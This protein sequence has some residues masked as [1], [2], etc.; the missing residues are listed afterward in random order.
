[1]L[2]GGSCLEGTAVKHGQG[3]TAQCAVPRLKH[4][5]R[6]LQQTLKQS[7]VDSLCPH[8]HFL[9]IDL[10]AEQPLPIPLSSKCSLGQETASYPEKT[11]HF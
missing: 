6:S 10:G 4:A 5:R 8:P 7:G 2:E 3:C 9:G 11:I 1:M